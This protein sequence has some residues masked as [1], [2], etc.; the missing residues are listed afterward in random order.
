MV[1][2]NQQ[3]FLGLEQRRLLILTHFISI[4]QQKQI[5]YEMKGDLVLSNLIFEECTFDTLD[6]GVKN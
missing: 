2:V 1:E 6:L 5:H 4:K 3:S